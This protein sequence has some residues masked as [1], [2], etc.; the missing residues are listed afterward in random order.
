MT[1]KNTMKQT[2][3]GGMTV[4]LL[5]LLFVLSG[6]G[7]VK[8]QTQQPQSSEGKVKNKYF[9]EEEYQK[10]IIDG[11]ISITEYPDHYGQETETV[12]S[13]SYPNIHFSD[14]CIFDPFPEDLS[15]LF[16]FYTTEQGMSVKKGIETLENWLESIGKSQNV[17]LEQEVRVISSHYEIDES[18]DAPECYPLL[19]ECDLKEL[20]DWDA[21]LLDTKEC[22][23]MVGASGM[24][25]MSDGKISAYLGKN[26]KP[27]DDIH[28]G[29]GLEL[30]QS[31]KVE[32]LKEESYPLLSGTCKIGE[33]ARRV[34]IYFEN[35][36]PF[37]M[38]EGVKID[39]P[40]V[41]VYR[42]DDATCMYHFNIRKWYKNMPCL[43]QQKSAFSNSYAGYGISDL[44]KNVNVVDDAGVST[45][46]GFSESDS[47]HTLYQ[48]TQIVGIKQAVD[49]ASQK[50]ASFLKLEVHNV[51][52]GYAGYMLD[53]GEGLDDDS[54]ICY[55]F[56]KFS[57]VNTVKN[58]AL[59]IYVDM[60]SGAVYYTFDN[61]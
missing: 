16:V 29:D 32:E 49:I 34:E 12:R 5:L 56:W 39:V 26:Q 38:A 7:N 59:N 21:L 33:S 24:F 51:E 31:G 20:K 30:L 15:E 11:R 18:K 37:S 57:G 48:D 10:K 8:N 52:I 35:G 54:T 61:V 36:T 19:S 13:L 44:Q 40:D 1:E 6:C 28:M 23:A 3:L 41:D 53:T 17:D 9:S 50:L 22:Y 47:I 42:L 45:F 27:L 25:Q 2:L 43:Y 14:D 58:Q 60:I 55:P 4:G 46:I